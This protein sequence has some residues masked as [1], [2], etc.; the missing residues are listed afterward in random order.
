MTLTHI[1][2]IFQVRCIFGLRGT[3]IRM[4][5]DSAF[6]KE[7]TADSEVACLSH[8][9]VFVCP[10]I[11]LGISQSSLNIL[12]EPV[13]RYVNLVGRGSTGTLLL[14]NPCGDLV[15]WPEVLA[16][17][18]IPLV[19]LLAS[20]GQLKQTKQCIFI[21]HQLVTCIVTVLDQETIPLMDLA[22]SSDQISSIIVVSSSFIILCSKYIVTAVAVDSNPATPFICRQ[23]PF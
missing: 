4:F 3:N 13:C 9:T 20:C 5:H 10:Y 18:S 11:L 23:M 14:E 15:T 2:Y 17:V 21:I 22:A 8:G 19:G 12:R 16:Q 7:L 1:F 6:T